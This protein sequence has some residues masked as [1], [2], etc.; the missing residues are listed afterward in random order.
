MGGNVNRK[1]ILPMAEEVSKGLTRA[2]EIYHDRSRRVKELKA[3]GKNVMGYLCLYPILEMLTAL[4]LVPYRIF[5]DMREPITRADACLPTVVCP[6]LR[7]CL[8]LG[9]KG[10]YD[11]LDGV[12][13]AHVCDVG[14]KTA[15]IWHIYLNPPYFHFIDIPHVVHKAAVTQHKELLKDF[16]KTLESFTGKELSPGKL[17]EAIEA[18]N[19]QRALVRELYELRKPDPP[20]ISGTETLQVMVALAS[21][22]VEEGSRLL[23]EVISEVKERKDGPQKK[24]VRL[25]IW[26]SILDDIALVEMIEGLDANVVMDDTCV[27]SRGYFPDVELTEDPFD[28]LAYRYLVEL[29]CP[30]TFK[31]A[32]PGEAKKDYMAD[33]ESRFSYLKDYVKEWNAKGVILQALRYCDVHGYEVPGLKDYFDH[34][35]VPNI[36]LEPDYSEA[37]LAPLRTRVQGFLEVVG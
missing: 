21:L 1:E 12:V 23:R 11:F 3:E 15:H 4:D 10:K 28:G 25:V 33:L 19:R 36:Y 27:G 29:K 16:K 30:R 26:G 6:F 7:S 9:L 17:R 8:D 35:G 24:P 37:A 2:R 5:G 34:V 18:H 22:P 31:E 13:M 20:L 32:A 14:E